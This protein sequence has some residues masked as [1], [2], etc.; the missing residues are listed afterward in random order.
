MESYLDF[1]K[2]YEKNKEIVLEKFK[3]DVYLSTEVFNKI[4]FLSN[5]YIMRFDLGIGGNYEK[6]DIISST[7]YKNLQN[8]KQL[9]I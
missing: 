7:I 6:A 2:Q 3:N 4:L 5:R 9:Y 8:C 1:K